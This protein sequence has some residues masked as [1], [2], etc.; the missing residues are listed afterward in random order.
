M[1]TQA[2]AGHPAA[3]LP[4]LYDELLAHCGSVIAAAWFAQVT[5]V[6]GIRVTVGYTFVVFAVHV[7]P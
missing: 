4:L 1:F 3:L 2:S 6:V 5:V 7:A